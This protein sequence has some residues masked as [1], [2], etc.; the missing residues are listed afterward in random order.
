MKFTQ[1]KPTKSDSDNSYE[2]TGS[3]SDGASTVIG[4]T[5]HDQKPPLDALPKVLRDVSKA[6]A[7]AQCVPESFVMY[8]ALPHVAAAIGN[9][10]EAQCYADGG[11]EP[12]NLWTGNLVSTGGGKTEVLKKLRRPF[13]VIDQGYADTFRE[14]HAQFLRENKGKNAGSVGDAPI[15]RHLLIDNA[16]M[17]SIF[18]MCSNN[19][20]GLLLSQPEGKLFFSM[21]AYRH[22]ET[23]EPNY[24][25]LYDREYF[26]VS[27]RNAATISGIGMLSIAMMIQPSNFTVA[28]KKN[29]GMMTSGLLA[30]LNLHYP[31]VGDYQ[32]AEQVD[33][34][35]YKNWNE[36][37]TGII[38]RRTDGTPILVYLDDR[39]QATWNNYMVDC[40]NLARRT[41][42]KFAQQANGWLGGYYERLHVTA[43]RL[44]LQFLRFED[45]G[46]LMKPS[47]VERGIAVAEYMKTQNERVAEMFAGEGGGSAPT[48]DQQEILNVLRKWQPA[49]EAE[50]KHHSRILRRMENL[51]EVLQQLV[52][53]QIIRANIR[54]GNGVEGRCITEYSIIAV[55]EPPVDTGKFW[56]YGYSNADDT[57]KLEV[58]VHSIADDFGEYQHQ[59]STQDLGARQQEGHTVA[60]QEMTAPAPPNDEGSCSAS[61]LP[62]TDIPPDVEAAVVKVQCDNCRHRSEGLMA[63]L[64]RVGKV[65]QNRPDCPGFRAT[66]SA[67][68]R[69]AS[70]SEFAIIIRETLNREPGR[71]VVYFETDILPYFDGDRV[72]A[73]S[74]LREFGFEV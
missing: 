4:N 61:Y 66:E 15:E 62:A 34:T 38:K 30:R 2:P 9:S 65:L 32:I 73:S 17:E 37:I 21:N 49:T 55:A 23:D 5:I 67:M 69:A 35:A 46:T 3:Q 68:D 7:K 10:I 6:I 72:P 71:N 26:K 43:I 56:G 51:H 64:C 41:S 22:A 19:P 33:T 42:R 36:S 16:T 28:I 45:G 44:A 74:F 47:F 24:C 1:A 20:H 11:T 60:E 40:R 29:P 18:F 54:E 57:S 31:I 52:R 13:A 53:S 59:E 58:S 50:L 12:V 48:D 39:A 14:E 25:K 8:A 70:L 63:G 27:R